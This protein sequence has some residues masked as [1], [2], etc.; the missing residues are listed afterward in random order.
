M[1]EELAFKAELTLGYGQNNTIS[2]SPRRRTPSFDWPIG[3]YAARR[4]AE[5]RLARRVC[6]C[7]RYEWGERERPV[8]ESMCD[9]VV[10]ACG[11]R[12]CVREIAYVRGGRR[13][14]NVSASAVGA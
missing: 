13:L 11:G 10:R 1:G 14:V 4:L 12:W 6:L 5:T 3:H 9:G 8:V 2:G 7:F